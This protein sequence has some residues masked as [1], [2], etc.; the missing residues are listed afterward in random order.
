M[1][2]YHSPE[3]WIMSMAYDVIAT[4]G[5]SKQVDGDFVEDLKVSWL[6]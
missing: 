2:H 4:S 5:V 6:E 1:K 3:I